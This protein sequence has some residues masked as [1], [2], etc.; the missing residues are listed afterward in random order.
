MRLSAVFRSTCLHF[1]L[2]LALTLFL[3]PICFRNFL[4]SPLFSRQLNLQRLSREFLYK[5]LKDGSDALQHFHQILAMSS[6]FPPNTSTPC[7]H[8]PV[9]GLHPSGVSGST[10]LVVTIITT[11]RR[12]EY[13]YLLQV[14]RGFLDRVSECGQDCST[15]QVLICN[16][17]PLPEDHSDACL[18]SQ[19]LP[20]VAR[21][22]SKHLDTAPNR[23]EQEKQDYSFCLSRTLETYNPEYVLLVEDDAVPLK[24]IFNVFFHLV[25][26][27]FPHEPLGGGLY[28]KFYHPER[29]QGYINPE[30]MRI[31]E[32]IGLG[33][34]A[35]MVLTWV[36]TVALRQQN[37]RWSVF[38]VFFIYTML[39]AELAGR[40]YLLELRR[41]SPA[42]YNIVPVTEC[43][44]PAML[45][46]ETSARRTLSYL[47]EI[48]CKPGYAKDIALY[49]ELKK[50]GELAWALEP[51]MVKHIGMFSTLR[52]SYEGEEPQ[53]L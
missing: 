13:H 24:D 35:G 25:Q 32:W 3:A 17:D 7:G 46:S 19:F 16:V 4:Y 18:L 53:L 1:I 21:Y 15:F 43:C 29:L 5:N 40:H 47:E 22:Q 41:I 39:L 23:F 27:R 30:P 8:R 44:T 26:V 49:Q 33:G 45:F 12:L 31:L 11:R 50:R 36:Y 42:L 38:V 2:L 34:L 48:Q 14:A 28:V 9:G 6:A 20:M 10:T 52:G 37:F 51:N